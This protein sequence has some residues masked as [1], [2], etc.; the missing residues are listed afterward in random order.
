F[1]CPELPCV[2]S[3]L[4]SARIRRPL[5]PNPPDLSP[6]LRARR[7]SCVASERESRGNDRDRDKQNS[8][9]HSSVPLLV[10]ARVFPLRPL[11]Q[12]TQRLFPSPS[13]QPTLHRSPCP[14]P[15]PSHHLRTCV[16]DL[17]VQKTGTRSILLCCH[18]SGFVSFPEEKPPCALHRAAS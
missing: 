7:V 4:T 18:K 1:G 12:G 10:Y 5:F 16:R 8:R 14:R 11:S 2:V 3:R 15:A 6:P 17:C 13:N 9:P